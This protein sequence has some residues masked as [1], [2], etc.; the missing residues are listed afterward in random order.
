MVILLLGIIFSTF[1]FGAGPICH[2][3]WENSKT[4]LSEEVKSVLESQKGETITLS[5]MFTSDYNQNVVMVNL[6]LLHPGVNFIVK[7]DNQIYNNGPRLFDILR[8]NSRVRVQVDGEVVT[9][10]AIGPNEADIVIMWRLTELYFL[11]RNL[12]LNIDDP[13]SSYNQ[14]LSD[15]Q[16]VTP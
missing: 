4:S 3:V 12:R 8:Q 5:E 7:V 1:S 9:S 16:G 10:E 13:V 6:L 14:L 11:G 2:S 15:L